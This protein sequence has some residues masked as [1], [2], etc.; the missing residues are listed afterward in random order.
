MIDLALLSIILFLLCYLAVRE[1]L[2]HS[3][4]KFLT[5]LVS[6]DPNPDAPGIAEPANPISKEEPNEIPLDETHPF[7]L[8]KEFNLEVEGQE[9][10]PVKLE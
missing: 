6:G 8:P 1:Y 7:V 5:K 2:Y 4:L 3:Q 9:P 10:R